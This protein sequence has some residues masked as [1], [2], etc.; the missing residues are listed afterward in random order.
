MKSKLLLVLLANFISSIKSYR[1]SSNGRK[2]SSFFEP[3]SKKL[4]VT[5]GEHTNINS[6]SSY[7][8]PIKETT[9]S[10][11]T[12]EV[13]IE[14]ILSS[15]IVQ[16]VDD[17]WKTRLEKQTARPYFKSLETF[18][19]SEMKN[20]TIF[21]PKSN[22]FAA[23]NLCPY[24]KVKVV[25]IGQDPYHGPNQAHGL[26][27]S[28]QKGNALPPSLR[29]MVTELKN[30]PELAHIKTPIHGD[31][32]SWSKQGVLLL[33]TCL[34]VRSGEANSHQK[35]GWEDFTDAVVKELGS[36]TGVVYLLWGKPA[37]LK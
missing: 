28:V 13:S 24:E 33:N 22:I 19:Q 5:E 6:L 29:N 32:S 1:M 10:S 12:T 16:V 8:G 11:S 30:D 34:T 4:K 9:I 36:R 14:N 26:A 17:G 15:L 7:P 27:F 2:I 20:K 3:T 18:V 31:L 23:F 37:Q 21:P 35:K 25:I